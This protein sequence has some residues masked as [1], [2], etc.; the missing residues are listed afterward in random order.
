MD[1]NDEQIREAIHRKILRLH[2]MAPD[3]LVVDELGI[4]HGSCR[5][6][7]AVING[8]LVGYEIKSDKDSLRRLGRQVR[9]YDA[10]FDS[11]TIVVGARFECRIRRRV[12]SHWGIVVATVGKRGAIHFATLRRPRANP[13][14]D[15]FSVAQ[16]LWRAEALKLALATKR[17]STCIASKRRQ[18]LYEHLV[19]NYAA[20]VLRSEVRSCLR[21]RSGWKDRRR[22]S[23][24]ADSFRLDATLGGRPA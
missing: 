9:T 19:A 12:P 4:R 17:G 1:A 11:V 14:V 24:G 20:D 3:T 8:R 21:N 22:P 23:Q 13:R 15:L 5:A 10:V 18:Q 6:D 2:H 7:I 16:L